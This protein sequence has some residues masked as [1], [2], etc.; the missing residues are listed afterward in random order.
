MSSSDEKRNKFH[1]KYIKQ[2]RTLFPHSKV[3]LVDL[4][5]T[6]KKLDLDKIFTFILHKGNKVVG[7]EPGGLDTLHPNSLGNAYM[8]K[9]I[10]KEAFGVEFD[11]KLFMKEVKR[12]EKYP[13]Y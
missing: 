5:K 6:S 8:A 9:S 1:E 4:F 3:K 10:L 2:S 12:G 11:P 7:I 13:R